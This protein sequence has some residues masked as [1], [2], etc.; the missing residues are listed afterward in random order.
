[1]IYQNLKRSQNKLHADCF[2]GTEVE[3]STKEG[4]ATDTGEDVASTERVVEAKRGVEVLCLVT[5]IFKGTTGVEDAWGD[6]V[7]KR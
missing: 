4:G 7:A 2:N 5:G 1:M 6:D 3:G